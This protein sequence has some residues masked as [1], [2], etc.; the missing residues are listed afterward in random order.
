MI[1]PLD[2]GTSS[3]GL[4]APASLDILESHG[5]WLSVPMGQCSLLDGAET[6]HIWDVAHGTERVRFDLTGPLNFVF[7]P[8]SRKLIGANDFHT[9]QV[10][11]IAGKKLLAILQGEDGDARGVATELAISPDG[12]Y[13][14]STEASK[15]VHLWNLETLRRHSLLRAH[16]FV[17]EIKSL[18]FS[19]DGQILAA[20]E[21]RGNV[22]VW[23]IETKKQIA[24]FKIAAFKSGN[25]VSLTFS[26]DGQYLLL[27]TR[28][29]GKISQGAVIAFRWR[30]GRE[31][32]R[33]TFKNSE[34]LPS[35]VLSQDGKHI[36]TSGDQILLWDVNLPS[37]AIE[38]MEN[39]SHFGGMSNRPHC[40]R[41]IPTRS[42]P[43][44]GYRINW[45]PIRLSRSQFTTSTASAFVRL[46]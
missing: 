24:A 15:I 46:T 36:I 7:S 11:D 33:L 23:N 6:V 22:I 34:V 9:V 30:D 26:P 17:S 3:A 40:F 39:S 42:T 10:W 19:P 44:R 31:V 28:R 14:A 20:S 12:K 21:W 41:T 29:F 43:K 27:E 5:C 38:P 32:D 37:L 18:A 13:L 1:T 16:L 2:F 8:D 35:V 25:I 4:S 45:H